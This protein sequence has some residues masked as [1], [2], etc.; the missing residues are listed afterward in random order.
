M[1]KN[2]EDSNGKQ[3][4]DI[5]LEK[6][7]EL[8]FVYSSKI[9]KLEVELEEKNSKLKKMEE[10]FKMFQDDFLYN[11]KVL[12]ER[13]K[14]LENFEK[15]II[16]LRKENEQ[17]KESIINLNFQINVKNKEISGLEEKNRKQEK[18]YEDKILKMKE[19]FK[20]ACNNKEKV[21]NIKLNDYIQLTNDL[22]HQL[23]ESLLK[24][25]KQK[26]TYEEEIKKLKEDVYNDINKALKDYESKFLSLESDN[27]QLKNQLLS[28]QNYNIILEKDKN[29]LM[30]KKS[31]ME[32]NM[33]INCTKWKEKEKQFND[34]LSEIIE[35]NKKIN[36]LLDENSN[37]IEEYKLKIIQ[38]ENL[39]N[40]SLKE[41]DLLKNHIEDLS[42][43][44]YKALDD[45]KNLN[46]TIKNNENEINSLNDELEKYKKSYAKQKNEL[47]DIKQNHEEKNNEINHIK[48]TYEK[49]NNILIEEINN[50]KEK[51]ENNEKNYKDK[52][53]EYEK[54]WE[55][56]YQEILTINNDNIKKIAFLEEKN[57]YLEQFKNLQSTLNTFVTEEIA[58]KKNQQLGIEIQKNIEKDL[59]DI[60]NLSKID[61]EL[62]QQLNINN[63]Q[64]VD[65]FNEIIDE[66]ISNDEYNREEYKDYYENRKKEDIYAENQTLRQKIIELQDQV[67]L[68]YINTFIIFSKRFYYMECI[69]K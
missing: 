1:L 20:D 14:E 43:E 66:N 33:Y 69:K 61:I 26:E 13:D 40:I 31:T 39:L 6:E 37:C 68:I 42:K 12:E 16:N 27:F 7:Q 58:K 19:E 53:K 57:S 21:L 44:N 30:E 65:N 63:T 34:R 45:I 24:T 64:I 18:I 4:N 9:K 36:N 10:K 15:T 62:P 41:N 23:S 55:C 56:K 35:E 48:E 8:L 60:D 22:K 25:K 32:R 51:L 38:K 5:V 28:L 52:L 2:L 54:T 46:K 59:S 17:K 50:L 11:L 67:M 3:Y 47:N 49:K 29:I